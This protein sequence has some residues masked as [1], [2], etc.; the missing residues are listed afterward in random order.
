MNVGERV[1]IPL[2]GIGTLALD[3]ETYKAGLA[4]GATLGPAPLSSDSSRDEP[5]LSSDE[6]AAL[7]SIP[8]S[9]I[10]QAARETRIPSHQFGRWRRFK[11]S[12]VEAATRRSD[13]R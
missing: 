6:L 11:R 5:L 9:W 1:L 8:T 12:E 7:L 10:E 13:L 3:S 2:P 4:A